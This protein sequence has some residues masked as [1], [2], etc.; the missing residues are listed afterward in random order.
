MNFRD[1]IPPIVYKL[2]GSP[3]A[4]KHQTQV[5]DSYAAA[6]ARCPGQAYEDHRL[7]EVIFQKTLHL[8]KNI[9]KSPLALTDSFLQSLS[10]ILLVFRHT[11]HDRLNV[12]DFGG[13][14][15]AHY[16]LLR[17]LL[18]ENLKIQW[19]V[20]ETPVMI[21]KAQ[22]LETDELH[23]CNSISAA[24]NMMS[25]INLIHSS[26][27]IQYLPDVES[28][29]IEMMDCMSTFLFFNRLVLSGKE[30]IV[31]I[32]ESLLSANGP[33]PMPAGLEDG[34]CRYPITYFPKEQLEHSV[35]QIYQIKFRLNETL[36]SFSGKPL[37]I[38][39]GFFAERYQ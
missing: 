17:S 20:V 25:D 9:D 18:P 6:S 2:K 37:F 13:A 14:C 29:L 30:K 16:F 38:N 34:L 15:G 32:Q 8:S 1:F 22:Q 3:A 26:G 5:F 10:A 7:V 33:G 27:T 4:R 21:A 23:F 19:I 31:T 39:S 12:L 24:R 11:Q 36:D 35:G 28:T